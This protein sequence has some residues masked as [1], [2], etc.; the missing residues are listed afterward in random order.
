MKT[1]PPPL[2][3]P[4]APTFRLPPSACD[5][6]VHVYGPEH[7]FP[8]APDRPYTPQDASA[9]RLEALHRLLGVERVVV[10]QA[11]V[12]GLDNGAM[13]DAVARDPHH[14]RG[15]ALLLPGTPTL[16][17]ER[18]HRA[19]VRGVRFNFVRH[20]GGAPDLSAVRTLARAIAPLGWHLQLH[21]DAQDLVTYRSFLD[22]LPV[23]FVIDHMGRTLVADGPD[24]PALA[25]LLDLLKDERAWVKLSGPERISDCLSRGNFPY[26]DVVPYAQRL[27]ATAPDRVLW[28]TDWPHPNVREM[29]DDGWLV[30]LL[31]HYGDP[32]AL[33]KLLVDNPTRLYWY[34]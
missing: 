1:V 24:Q 34:D 30:D 22:S 26:A 3:N 5:S 21:L 13:L 28:G 23:P 33:H 17:L 25:Q 29:P 6:H 8:Y 11:T 4:T 31:P 9:E 16:E 18:M 19:G 7:R 32:Q 27:M 20:L 15:V 2:D 10:V 12:H 14:R